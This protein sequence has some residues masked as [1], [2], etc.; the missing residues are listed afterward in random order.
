VRNNLCG[1]CTS[2]FGK[3]CDKASGSST[4]KPCEPDKECG[5]GKCS[6][7]IKGFRLQNPHGL[8]WR[9]ASFDP[10]TKYLTTSAKP[11]ASVTPSIW[12]RVPSPSTLK[13]SPAG[14]TWMCDCKHNGCSRC[15]NANEWT[16]YSTALMF[17]M[18]KS[19]V[20]KGQCEVDHSLIHP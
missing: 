17:S 13:K 5:K 10:D 15:I 14:P 2:L 9:G 8:R 20:Q 12:Q 1:E 16:R 7:F 6:G 3:K 18:G 4:D 11:D 19:S